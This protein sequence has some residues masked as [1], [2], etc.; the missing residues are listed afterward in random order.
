MI[1]CIVHNC[2]SF[3]HCVLRYGL[4]DEQLD[5]LNSCTVGTCASSLHCGWADESSDVKLDW[6]TCCIVHKCDSFLH[7][8]LWYL[9]SDHHLDWMN[10]Y[11]VFLRFI[12]TFIDH[13]SASLLHI[14]PFHLYVHGTQHRHPSYLDLLLQP[15]EF[16][17]RQG[18][19]KTK[20]PG[21]CEV[22]CVHFYFFRKYI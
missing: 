9:F 5:W 21:E 7:C 18:T 6:M 4:S 3:L 14:A 16:N 10:S 11:A 22:I 19:N 12:W 13:N 1:C 17:W 2:S 8:R 20:G 15:G